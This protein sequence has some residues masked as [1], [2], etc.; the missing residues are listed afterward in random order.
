MDTIVYATDECER[1]PF[2]T[3]PQ[4]LQNTI[5]PT[6]WEIIANGTVPPYISWLHNYVIIPN[7]VIISTPKSNDT[8]LRSPY[9][10]WWALNIL[11]NL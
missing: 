9:I 6:G 5:Q 10:S 7:Q 4:M 3:F 1:W 8:Q 11:C 2:M